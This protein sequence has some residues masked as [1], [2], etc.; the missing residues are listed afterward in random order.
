MADL[1]I[2]A[3]SVVT[4]A[5]GVFDKDAYFGEAVTAGMAVYKKSSDGKYWKAQSDG[6]AEESG[7]NVLFGVAMNGGAAGQ[8]AVVQRGGTVTIGA[9]IAAGV[10]YYISNT[11]GGICPVADLGSADY[12]SVI[13]YGTTTAILKISPVAS[14]VALA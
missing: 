2:T 7:S 12:P 4:A 10:F 13:G 3:N 6:T 9:T 11:A 5:D 8:P 14:G 1:S